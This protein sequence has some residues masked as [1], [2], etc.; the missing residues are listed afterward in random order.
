MWPARPPNLCQRVCYLVSEK[1]MRKYRTKDPKSSIMMNR[2]NSYFDTRPDNGKRLFLSYKGGVEGWM[3]RGWRMSSI[4]LTVLFAWRQ[5]IIHIIIDI[6]KSV[7]IPIEKIIHH[8]ITCSPGTLK[9][10]FARII[11]QTPLP[12]YKSNQ[13]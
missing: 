12:T 7:F 13:L 4:W 6:K 9:F 11:N 5:L 3:P 10:F 8:Y 1:K 2:H